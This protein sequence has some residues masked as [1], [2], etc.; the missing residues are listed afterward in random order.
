MNM[1]KWPPIVGH[2]CLKA[3]HILHIGP[4]IEEPVVPWLKYSVLFTFKPEGH[5]FKYT[6]WHVENEQI[7]FNSLLLS[8]QVY[9]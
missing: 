7:L 4:T 3:Y 5:G 2:I 1:K 8:I 9:K 6:P